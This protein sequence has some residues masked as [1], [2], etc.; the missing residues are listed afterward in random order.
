MTTH[1][2]ITTAIIP[3]IHIHSLTWSSVAELSVVARFSTF[4]CG[5][6]TLGRGVLD[7]I[8]LA[9]GAPLCE[10]GT[11]SAGSCHEIRSDFHG[12]AADGL[13]REPEHAP[14]AGKLDHGDRDHGKDTRPQEPVT[15]TRVAFCDELWTQRYEAGHRAPLWIVWCEKL[16][17][18]G[19]VVDKCWANDSPC[20][21][22]STDRPR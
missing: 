21:Y 6:R 16:A 4:V 10:V 14:L 5:E 12:A 3:G 7:E 8:L 2:R 19:T 18:G 1:A 17:K 22:G 9:L 20:E 13:G 11:R 15:R